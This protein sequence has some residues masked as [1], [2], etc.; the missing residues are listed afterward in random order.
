MSGL[1]YVTGAFVAP[2]SLFANGVF[3]NAN[4][5]PATAL[6]TAAVRRPYHER[7]FVNQDDL[8]CQRL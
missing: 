2:V 3:A 6:F 5:E 4:K 8:P 1:L 7:A